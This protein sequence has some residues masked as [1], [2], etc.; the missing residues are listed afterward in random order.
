MSKFK[1]RSKRNKFNFIKDNEEFFNNDIYG[2]H[3]QILSNK[4]VIIEGCKKIIDYQNNNLKLKLK[5]GYI[6]ILGTDFIIVSF[7]NGKIII[8]GNISS[9]EFCI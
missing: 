6:N 7:D 2:V 5:K 4:K 8:K 1:F 3:T 9:I